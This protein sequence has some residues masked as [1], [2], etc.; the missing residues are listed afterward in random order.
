M[1]ALTDGLYANAADVRRELG[2]VGTIEPPDPAD[3]MCIVGYYADLPMFE[4]EAV[5][6]KNGETYCAI[7]MRNVDAFTPADTTVYRYAIRERNVGGED[8]ETVCFEE[9]AWLSGTN[10]VFND[11][12]EQP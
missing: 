7:G 9:V 8:V 2:I 1:S 3:V 10:V 5:W 11:E 12:D 4:V 6:K